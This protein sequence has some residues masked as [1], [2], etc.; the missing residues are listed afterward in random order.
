M[1]EK[2]YATNKRLNDLQK[3]IETMDKQLQERNREDE[4]VYPETAT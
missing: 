3:L 1:N 2:Y 4:D